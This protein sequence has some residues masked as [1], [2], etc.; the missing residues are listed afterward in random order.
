M[1][2]RSLTS[3]VPL[4]PSPTHCGTS[5]QKTLK[6]ATF[7]ICSVKGGGECDFMEKCGSKVDFGDEDGD[8]GGNSSGADGGDGVACD[9][10]GVIDM[11]DDSDEGELAGREGAG[12]K[13]R[14][15]ASEEA[16]AARKM[17]LKLAEAMESVSDDDG[18]D[19]GEWGVGKPP[20]HTES[21]ARP[22]EDLDW[23][24][25]MGAEH[26]V[27]ASS[28]GAGG[29]GRVDGG[30]AAP[31]RGAGSVGRGVSRSTEAAGPVRSGVKLPAGGGWRLD[32]DGGLDWSPDLGAEHTVMARS[33]VAGSVRGRLGQAA[34]LV[35]SLDFGA[36]HSLMASSVGSGR[37][38]GVGGARTA[39]R[40]G[41]AADRWSPD[42]GAKHPVMGTTGR[43]ASVGID[44]SLPPR[45]D[46]RRGGGVPLQD[47]G[48][49][50]THKGVGLQYVRPHSGVRTMAL[51]APGVAGSTATDLSRGHSAAARL[52]GHEKNRATAGAL[53]GFS[54]GWI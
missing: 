26:T 25:D 42:L 37:A 38:R 18:D 3:P 17:R 24:P 9:E 20:S 45:G 15:S 50:Y 44:E 28:T 49:N 39:G 30:V 1:R 53:P 27:P 31:A 40:V 46:G 36:E 52:M 34:S 2:E 16:N 51:Q 11:G 7:Y 32:R 48:T 35:S 22:A 41:M 12:E 29:A 8:D 6:G 10:A 23:S 21:S 13:I 14:G 4:A 33:E 47:K 43:A 19:G 5:S 54:T